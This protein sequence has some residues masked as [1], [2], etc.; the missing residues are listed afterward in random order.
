MN[1]HWNTELYDC[2]HDFV[3]QMGA[4]VV[5]LLNPQKGEAILDLGC[6]TGHLTAQIADSGAHIIGFDAS[7]SMIETAHKN[8][9]NLDLRLADARFFDFDERFDAVFSNATLHWI[10]E[11]EKPIARVAHHLKTGGRFVAEMGGQGNVAAL[12]TALRDA[13]QSLSLPAFEDFNYFPSIGQY[14]A[15]LEAGGF[16]VRFATLF[17]RPTP[18]DGENGARNWLIQFRGAYLDTLE[19]ESRE[20]VLDEAQRRLHPILFQNGQWFADYRRLRFVAVKL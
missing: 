14:T 9:S 6:G 17:D 1:P 7:Q 10:H 3:W 12:E 8:Y 2:N 18:L 15:Q 19:S 20:A 4:G 11:S 5:E 13:A 16:E